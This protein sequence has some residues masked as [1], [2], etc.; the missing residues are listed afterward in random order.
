[1][2]T[3]LSLLRGINVSGK[4]SMRMADLTALYA[5]L[6]LGHVQS[7]LQ[8]GN[9]IFTSDAEASTLAA[10]IGEAIQAHYG[11]QVTVLMRQQADLERV[12]AANP[13]LKRNADP[14]ALYVTFLAE[15]PT[16]T[17]IEGL[18]KSQQGSDEFYVVGREIYLHCPHG[19]GRTKLS[20]AFFERKLKVAATTR[21][22]ENSGRAGRPSPRHLTS[23]GCYETT[24]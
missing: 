24:N 16:A 20:N 18:G 15:V 8:S 6:G 19:Y 9:L 14:Q 11:F 2:T 13:F 23:K 7:Y 21:N 1:M 12:L 22:L 3:F 17:E 5:G 4:K 10:R